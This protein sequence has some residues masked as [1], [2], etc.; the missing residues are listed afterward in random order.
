MYYTCTCNVLLFA[1]IY[2]IG[3]RKQYPAVGNV[4]FFGYFCDIILYSHDKRRIFQER[5]S[6][7]VVIWAISRTKR[8]T[9]C[10]GDG[11]KWDSIPQLYKWLKA[12]FGRPHR[13]YREF[14]T[15]TRQRALRNTPIITPLRIGYRK[16]HLTGKGGIFA[17]KV[18]SHYSRVSKT[19]PDKEKEQRESYYANMGIENDTRL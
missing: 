15:K 7:S 19:I 5:E 17:T 11:H 4:I 16:Q 14:Y 8:R 3:Y 9:S 2:T 6:Y 12:T 10:K 13:Q 18:F 1:H